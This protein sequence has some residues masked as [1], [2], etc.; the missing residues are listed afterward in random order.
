MGLMAFLFFFALG[1]GIDETLLRI[2]R[3]NDGFVDWGIR[4][5]IGDRSVKLGCPTIIYV[6]FSLG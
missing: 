5:Y 1:T 6:F 2:G 4:V 3:R